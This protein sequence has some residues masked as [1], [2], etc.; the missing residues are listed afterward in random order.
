MAFHAPILIARLCLCRGAEA[1]L[2]SLMLLG[3][4]NLSEKQSHLALDSVLK[5]SQASYTCR[6]AAGVPQSIRYDDTCSKA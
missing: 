3:K 4:A 6:L 2:K 1:C 5:E